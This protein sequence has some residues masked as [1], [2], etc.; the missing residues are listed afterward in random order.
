MEKN[1]KPSLD[2]A[3]AAVSEFLPREPRPERPALAPEIGEPSVHPLGFGMAVVRMESGEKVAR[4]AWK[5]KM[6]IKL[7]IPDAGSMMSLPYIYMRTEE[8]KLIPWIPG[9]TEILA[10]DWVSIK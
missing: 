3:P 4:M 10:K 2:A 9:M 1:Q 6:W 5:N 8:G 7:Q